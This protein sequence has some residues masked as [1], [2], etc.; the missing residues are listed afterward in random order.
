MISMIGPIS[1][2]FGTKIHNACT[3]CDIS[4]FWW[5]QIIICYVLGDAI[6]HPKITKNTQ[7]HCFWPFF[8]VCNTSDSRYGLYVRGVVV[9]IPK[10]RILSGH[11]LGTNFWPNFGT[12]TTG[13]RFLVNIPWW[14]MVKP[15]NFDRFSWFR[16]PPDHENHGF[17]KCQKLAHAS[18]YAMVFGTNLVQIWSKSWYFGTK[19]QNGP[20]WH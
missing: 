5:C 19:H 2:W 1:H 3:I 14:V 6:Q 17:C 13:A 16:D 20:K 8:G 15:S 18:E 12:I 10:I 9:K 4:S 11:V 7:K